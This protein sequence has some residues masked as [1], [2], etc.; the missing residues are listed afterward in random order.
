MQKNTGDDVSKKI[1][2]ASTNI[3]REE[4]FR[5]LASDKCGNR[6]ILRRLSGSFATANLNSGF[7]ASQRF[8]FAPVIEQ[9]ELF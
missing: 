6:E 9:F 7:A 5:D 1:Q 2:S 8:C 4:G 3:H